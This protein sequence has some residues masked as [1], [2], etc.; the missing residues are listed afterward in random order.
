MD[1]RGSGNS[2]TSVGSG[3]GAVPAPIAF[4][5]GGVI[6]HGCGFVAG[7]AA[8]ER[9]LGLAEGPAAVAEGLP[10]VVGHVVGPHR[11][12]QNVGPPACVSPSGRRMPTPLWE[13]SR[14]LLS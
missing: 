4:G 7:C 3:A 1:A 14:R 6:E 12:R 13:A 2:T 8:G 9:A 5:D 11:Q 10:V